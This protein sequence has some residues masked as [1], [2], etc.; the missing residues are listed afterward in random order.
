MPSL[1][2]LFNIWPEV[3]ATAIRQEKGING[4]QIRKKEM[5][6]SFLADDMI[7]YMENPIDTT[8]NL[9]DLISELWQNSRIHSQYSE[10]KGILVHQQWKSRNRNQEKNPIWYSIRKIKYLGINLTK[11]VKDL[12]SE[13]YTTLKKELRRHK[14]M[15]ACTMLMDWKN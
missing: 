8:K 4:I 6:L 11:E 12:Y 14:Q 5:K 13:N 3:L 10:I 15:E 9:L 1:T 2:L 7:V